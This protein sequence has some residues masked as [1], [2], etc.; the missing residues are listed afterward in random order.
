MILPIDASRNG[1]GRLY[2]FRADLSVILISS[3]FNVSFVLLG[4]IDEK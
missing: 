2:F 3:N 4:G 1:G